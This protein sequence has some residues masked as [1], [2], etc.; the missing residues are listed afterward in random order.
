MSLLTPYMTMPLI[1]ILRGVT[2][3]EVV[4]VTGALIE[5]GFTMIEVPLNSP[6]AVESIRRIVEAFGDKALI[7]AGTVLTVEEVE[8][9]AA[10][11]GKLIVSPNINVDV[12]KRTKE[13]GM[14]SAPGVSTPTELFAAIQAG[15]D[16]AKAFPADAIPPSTIKAWSS[17]TPKG[18]P[19]LAVGGVNADNMADYLAAGA[20]GFGIGSNLY[21]HGKTVD[22]VRSVAKQLVQAISAQ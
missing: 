9:V 4:E 13:L 2:E 8:A 3:D 6:N 1:A 5:E 19:I 15:A 21:K 22:E 16:A 10:V 7:G 18:Y 17:V 20:V 12:V 14:I 11:G